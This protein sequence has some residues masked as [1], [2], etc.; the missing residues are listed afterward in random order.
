MASEEMEEPYQIPN[1]YPKGRYLLL[2]DPLDGS[3]NIDVN[4][5]IGTIFSI[6]ECPPD[7][8]E[9]DESSF[10]QPGARQ[11]AAG[12]AVYG[13]STVMVLTVGHG[14][15]GFTLD[16]A[17]RSRYRRR[18]SRSTPRT[19]ATGRRRSGATS[20]NASPARTARWAR[21]STCAG[22]HRWSPTS[23]AS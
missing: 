21:T 20:T 16:R 18:N 10:L 5:S 1:E 4:V 15:V 3:S 6:L 7:V 12:F 22:S 2:F 19:R 13:P 23:T 8:T 9:P 17:S 11:V 14:T